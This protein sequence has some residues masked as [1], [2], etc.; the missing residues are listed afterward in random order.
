MTPPHN[1]SHRPQIPPSMSPSSLQIYYTNWA[2]CK[3]TGTETLVKF[4]TQL[5]FVTDNPQHGEPPRTS[6]NV[7]AP[8]NRGDGHCPNDP[9]SHDLSP[10]YTPTPDHPTLNLSFAT[11]FRRF[12]TIFTHQPSNL[13]G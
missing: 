4:D 9:T 13:H 12:L 5:G 2:G 7:T 8:P 3:V 10:G 6:S 1:S 11:L